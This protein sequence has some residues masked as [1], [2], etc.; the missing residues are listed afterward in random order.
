MKNTSTLS[1]F[2]VL[3]LVYLSFYILMPQSISSIDTPLNEF[4]TERALIPLKEITKA[5]HY[6]GNVE[7]RRVRDF[8]F[9][10]LTD[11]GVNPEIQKG[12]VLNE[13]SGRMNKPINIVGKITGTD[14]GKSLLIFSHY[15]SALIPSFGASD[16][17]SGVVTILESIR[18]FKSTGKK[19]KNDIIILF[20]DAEEVGL[21]GAKL[22]VRSHRWAK[23]IGL[24]LNFEARGSGGPSSMI[25]E[26]NHGNKNLIKAFKEAHPEYPVASSLLYSI[27][28]M[29]PNDTDSTIFR[30]EGD[31]DGLF[32]AFIDDHF[33]YHTAG[34]NFD[35]M[36][37]NSLEHQGSY[38]MPLLSYFSDVNLDS[39]KSSEDYVYTNFPF[40]NMIIYPFS[41]VAPLTI[42]AIVVFILLLIFGFKNKKLNSK[43]ILKGFIP[44][45]LSLLGSFILGF[46]G[47]PILLKIYPHYNEILQGFT[48]NGHTYIAFFVSLTITLFWYLYTKFQKNETS[49]NLFVAPLFVWII[50]NVF[51]AFYLKGASYFI[52]PFYCALLSFWILLISDK[53][54]SFVH[55]FLA[56]PALFIFGPLI[57]TFP[58]G[59]GL[60]LIVISTVF[61]VLLFGL[62]LSFLSTFNYKNK[63]AQGFMFI[64]IFLFVFA[65]ANS[66]F[67]EDR[68][69]PNSLVYMQDVDDKKSKW[70][71]YDRI[72]DDWTKNYLSSDPKLA[73]KFLESAAKSKYNSGYTF[74]SEAP[75]E[76]I[77]HYQKKFVQDTIIG[78]NRNIILKLIPEK[79]ADLLR[80]YVNQ[81]ITFNS[82]SFNGIPI[83]KNLSYKEY[84]NRILSFFVHEMDSLEISYSFSKKLNPTFT[85]LEYSFDLMDNPWLNV[86]PRSN[87]MMPK[88]FVITDALIVKQIIKR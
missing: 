47:W 62:L 31:I 70:L 63:A 9:K 56:I 29:L 46:L 64:S 11:L 37:R 58:V 16:A 82:L 3:V 49:P 67:N 61:T 71:T 81:E 33:D 12:Y 28:K 66:D 74:A 36:D 38:L 75:W 19:P 43:S 18:A 73:S 84:N 65:H 83:S 1:F 44:F 87:S 4:S 26:T 6:V 72:L 77:P 15:D 20:T 23:N 78:D 52:L 22:F 80:L 50:I 59:L 7:N 53:S 40:I 48:Y 39:I 25:V 27:Y 24:S 17:G 41:W 5:P 14:S 35:R 34:D 45:L 51:I 55:L 60:K 30:K 42:I 85:L 10:S 76:I 54:F 79:K 32:F 88:P 13:K 2:F 86:N 57:K 21:V 8:L 69:K 68:K